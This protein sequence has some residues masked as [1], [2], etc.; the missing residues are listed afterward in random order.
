MTTM[1]RRIRLILL[2]VVIAV[3]ALLLAASIAVY[4]LLQPKRITDMLRDQARQAGLALVLGAPAEPTLWPQPALVLHSLTLS[5]NNRPV[6]VAA[7][8]RVVLPWRTLLGGPPNITR[9]ELDAPRLHI[10]QLGRLFGDRADDDTPPTLPHVKAGMRISHGSIM[11]KGKLMLDGLNLE[12]GPLLPGRVFNLLITASAYEHPFK[13]T[14]LTTPRQHPDAIEFDNI[15]INV[16]A[17]SDAGLVLDG[18]AIWHGDTGLDLD[19]DG[20]LRRADGRTYR[21]VLQVVPPATGR[22]NAFRVALDGPGIHADLDMP[23]SR[24]ADWWQQVSRPDTTADLPLPPLDGHI[25]IERLDIG[26]TH[27]EGMHLSTGSAAP[28]PAS[29]TPATG[30]SG[31]AA[32]TPASP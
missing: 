32:A 30:G 17:D 24:L 27:V 18:R 20:T 16:D 3:T 15:H 2:T 14:L 31:D 4:S 6:L 9:L 21:T 29:S 5:S 10:D 26:G 11:N 1:H 19:L 22:S 12:T 23:P 7:R 25:D 8:A 28:A 13:L